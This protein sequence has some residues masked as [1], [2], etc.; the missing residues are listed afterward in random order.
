M[1]NTKH[2]SKI[3]KWALNWKLTQQN[4]FNSAIQVFSAKTDTQDGQEI[5]WFTQ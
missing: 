2:M 5:I 3:E 1:E 4:L